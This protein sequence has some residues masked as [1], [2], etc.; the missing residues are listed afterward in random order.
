MNLDIETIATIVPSAQ[1]ARRSPLQELLSYFPSR[2]GLGR[3]RFGPAIHLDNSRT[4]TESVRAFQTILKAV[5]LCCFFKKLNSTLSLVS[6]VEGIPKNYTTIFRKFKENTKN[7]SFL[8]GER[9]CRGPR[10]HETSN[11]TLRD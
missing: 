6:D 3:N 10:K 5:V 4:P 2:V 1:P 11:D 7:A 9:T 8:N